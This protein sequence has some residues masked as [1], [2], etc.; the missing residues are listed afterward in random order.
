[1]AISFE[2]NGN[3]QPTPLGSGEIRGHVL[4]C[5]SV[6]RHEQC[7]SRSVI[8]PNGDFLRRP[9]VQDAFSHF[10]PLRILFW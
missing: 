10:P 8:V 3:V 7:G 1:M 5:A 4:L 9:D 6:G 2:K